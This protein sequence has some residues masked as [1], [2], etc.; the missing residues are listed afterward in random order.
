MTSRQG[1]RQNPSRKGSGVH[2]EVSAAKDG[3]RSRGQ[4]H[5]PAVGSPSRSRFNVSPARQT[6]APS[7]SSKPSLR[8]IPSNR[9]CPVVNPLQMHDIE[10]IAE[11]DLGVSEE[12]MT[13][14]AARGIAEVTL[15]AVKPRERQLVKGNTN[16]LPVVVVVV[17]NNKSGTRAVA[18][19]RHLRNH[20]V[21]VMVCCI[22]LER[23]GELPEGL[24]RQLT[25]FENIGGKIS[26]RQALSEHLKALDAPPELIVDA[27][28]GMHVSLDDL[29]DVEQSAAY[30]MIS[31]MNKSKANVLAVDVPTGIDASTGKST[32]VLYLLIATDNL[33]ELLQPEKEKSSMCSHST[34]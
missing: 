29:P 10:N 26:G 31:W 11:T 17:G 30:E 16:P 9:P 14:N 4:Q 21:R 19:A 1:V 5:S 15:M 8:I 7:A 20:G 22:A 27:L 13:E 24:K 3:F 34:L 28:M 32:M 12:M 6:E 23:H 18:A 33:Q 25:M 2:Q